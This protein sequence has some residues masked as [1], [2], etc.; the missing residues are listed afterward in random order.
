VT[1]CDSGY[2]QVGNQ[3]LANGME[4]CSNGA[5][6]DGDNRVD[7]LDIDCASSTACANKCID[8]KQV[9][10]DAI[11]TG[12]GTMAAGSTQ[13]IASYSCTTSTYGGSE[14]AY[15]FTGSANQD[16]FVEIYGLSGN[17]GIFEIDGTT[18]A[19][20]AAASACALYG[21]ASTASSPEALGFTVQ[22]GRD[23]YLVVDGA[24]TQTYSM[25]VQC[26][27]AGGCRPTKAIGV[28]QSIS[29]T[30]NPASGAS[31]ITNNNGFY[32]CYSLQ[33]TGPEAA[34]MFT[35]TVTG[36]YQV[37]LSGLTSDC[38]LF[39]LSSN[40]CN[41]TCLTPTSA[42]RSTNMLRQDETVTFSGIANTTYY[43]VVEG[44]SG[45]TCS[46]T[47]SMTQL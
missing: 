3:C 37:R 15:R 2:H 7:C 9:G 35:P 34:W 41:G 47:L 26:S 5:D 46:F 10:C 38:D 27:T 33:E 28:G 43:I 16:V 23:Y 19:Q 20:C 42:S 25:S 39:V 44:W 18:G 29:A 4:N 1:A 11:L 32:S 31:N 13:R 40:N 45:N 30:N 6:D 24:A 36:S 17:L 21:D 14:Y 12:Q 8:A 22:Q